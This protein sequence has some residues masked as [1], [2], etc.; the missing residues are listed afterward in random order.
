MT[1]K[2]LIATGDCDGFTA[3]DPEYQKE[4]DDLEWQEMKRANDC[5]AYWDGEC[6]PWQMAYLEAVYHAR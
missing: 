5:W 6:D 1:T 2:R 4:L 3:V